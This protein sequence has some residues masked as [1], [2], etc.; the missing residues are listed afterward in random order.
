MKSNNISKID[1][2]EL[3]QQSYYFEK[4]GNNKNKKIKRRRTCKIWLEITIFGQQSHVYCNETS[5]RKQAAASRSLWPLS[6]LEP[7]QMHNAQGNQL[8]KFQLCE[9][10]KRLTTLVPAPPPA[11]SPPPHYNSGNHNGTLCSSL[12]LMYYHDLLFR[13]YIQIIEEKIINLLILSVTFYISVMITE[14]MY[15]NI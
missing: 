5:S 2:R 1:K 10:W 11:P 15:S 3:W 4:E 12:I 14:A 13:S 7:A 6:S 9:E 8:L